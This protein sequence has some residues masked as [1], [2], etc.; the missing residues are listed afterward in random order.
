MARL[1]ELSEAEKGTMVE[2]MHQRGLEAEKG[3]MV[4]SMH[5]RGYGCLMPG[6]VHGVRRV[7]CVP[8]VRPRRVRPVPAP[9][10]IAYSAPRRAYEKSWARLFYL[11]NSRL[12]YV[13]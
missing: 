9:S 8:I 7:S 1:L 2:S 12:G 13:V 11:I 3:T 5:Q 6:R 10:G 4:E